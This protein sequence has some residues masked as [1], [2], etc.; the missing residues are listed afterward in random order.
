MLSGK[1]PFQRS[2]RD[3]SAESIMRKIRGGEFSVRGKEWDTVSD[4]AK[5]LIKGTKKYYFSM[6]Y[7]FLVTFQ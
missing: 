6:L 2:S 3:R 4:E 5:K 1:V 7:A